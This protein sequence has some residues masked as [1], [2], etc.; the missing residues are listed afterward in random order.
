MALLVSRGEL[1][2]EELLEM[3]VRRVGTHALVILAGEVDLSTVGQVYEELAQL[4][5]D[6]VCHI[7]INFAEVTFIDSS[8]LSLL[9]TEHKSADAMNGELIIFSP[10]HAFRRLLQISGLDSYLNVRPKRAPAL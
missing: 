3:E 9:V 6:G 5:R 2:A 10:S 4:T 7:A 1:S 8:G